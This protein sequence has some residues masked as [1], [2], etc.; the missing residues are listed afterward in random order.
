MYKSPKQK[1]SRSTDHPQN[2]LWRWVLNKTNTALHKTWLPVYVF[3]FVLISSTKCIARIRSKFGRCA[4]S[5]QDIHS[6]QPP[7]LKLHCAQI[8]GKSRENTSQCMQCQLIKSM[9]FFM[10]YTPLNI[11]MVGHG[12][13][14]PWPDTAPQKPRCHVAQICIPVFVQHAQIVPFV[15][16]PPSTK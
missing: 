14:T 3:S 9:Q 2:P 12:H 8:S 5:V 10:V 4:H 16:S 6:T 15:L 11:G 1:I 13:Y 7:V